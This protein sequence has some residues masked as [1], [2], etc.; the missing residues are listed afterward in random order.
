[1][2]LLLVRTVGLSSPLFLLLCLFFGK[3]GG[4]SSKAKLAD[5]LTDFYENCRQLW[6]AGTPLHRDTVEVYWEEV[7]ES[8]FRCDLEDDETQVTVVGTPSA[9]ELIVLCGHV[10]VVRG[11]SRTPMA[12]NPSV[13]HPPPPFH[14][15]LL[16]HLPSLQGLLSSFMVTAPVETQRGRWRWWR[17]RRRHAGVGRK[18][19]QLR[20][21]QHHL[22]PR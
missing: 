6:A 22:H 1:M 15:D 11:C 9:L 10:R 2:L 14:P 18:L 21:L 7:L 16:P 5:A 8:D 20:A 17:Q 4:R 13:Q 19:Q 3:W 12:P